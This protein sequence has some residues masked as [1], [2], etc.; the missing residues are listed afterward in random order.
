LAH[1]IT[2]PGLRLSNRRIPGNFTKIPLRIGSDAAENAQRI[3]LLRLRVSQCI[4]TCPRKRSG[5]CS[6]E[7]RSC[8]DHSLALPSL[9]RT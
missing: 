5:T 7:Q 9:P 4:L 3:T 2:P 8:H 6:S 1:Q